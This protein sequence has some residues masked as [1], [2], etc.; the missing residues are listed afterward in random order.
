MILH[1][2]SPHSHKYKNCQIKQWKQAI[3]NLNIKCTSMSCD[4]STSSSSSTMVCSGRI[5]QGME[6][7]RRLDMM[8][9]D[10]GFVLMD[11]RPHLVLVLGQG[12]CEGH[13]GWGVQDAG[14]Q[15]EWWLKRQSEVPK[16]SQQAW[17]VLTHEPGLSF[18]NRRGSNHRTI[19]GMGQSSH[20][21]RGKVLPCGQY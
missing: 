2:K 8:M 19:P 12:C 4:S 13:Y 6:A 15:S 10:N 7:F 3:K 11:S 9:V 21:V 17:L 18:M 16:N 14:P 1:I 20:G 5:I